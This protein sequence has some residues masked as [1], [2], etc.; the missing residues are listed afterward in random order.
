[1]VSEKP[2]RKPRSKQEPAVIDLEATDT[3]AETR[4]AEETTVPVEAT[5]A[6]SEAV[7]EANSAELAALGVEDE[8]KP[9]E[10]EAPE[11]IG[12]AEALAAEPVPETAI[13]PEENEKPAA[14]PSPTPAPVR[15][16]TSTTGALAAGIVGGL[17]A[18]A[19]AGAMQYAGYLPAPT[20]KPVAAPA[21]DTGALEAE[22]AALKNQVASLAARPAAP[23][24]DTTAL[25]SRLAALEARPADAPTTD[26]APLEQKLTALDGQL[27]QLEGAMAGADEKQQSI[28]TGLIDRLQK[29]ETEVNDPSRRNA[30]ARAIAA[31][32]LKAAIDRGGSFVTEL[33]TFAGVAADETAVTGLKPFAEAGVPT[34][35]ALAAAFPDAANAVLAALNK[36]DPS[37]GFAERLWSSALSLVKV[38]PV[39]E[40]EGDTPE[41][42]LA[43]SENALKAGDL[44]KAL[45]E[46]N[47]LPEEGRAAAPD[48]GKGLA[49]R[50]E[51][52]KLVGATLRD[53][54]T[55]VTTN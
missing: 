35:A 22:L 8:P 53:A 38:R 49:A 5:P 47:R 28:Q 51:V 3:T 42:L 45:A 52:E 23:V 37:L 16:G 33:E 25:E 2:S 40:V 21:A 18:L 31:S 41:A 20:P 32:G 6:V 12:T 55:G 15:Q 27:S 36:P 19:A 24:A 7:A 50:I 9:A 13:K 10:D 26:L 14:E 4:P 39:G 1:M 46:W 11:E 17:V 44:E 43:R 34:R 30:V 54:V 29:V 48:F